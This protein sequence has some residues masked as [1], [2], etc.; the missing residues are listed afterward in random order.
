MSGLEIFLLIIL[1]IIVIGAFFYFMRRRAKSKILSERYGHKPSHI[2]LYFEEYFDDIIH[3]WDLVEKKEAKD[4]ANNMDK[5]LGE[6]S[7]EI[8]ELQSNKNRISSEFD[9]I[10]DRVHRIERKSKEVE[11]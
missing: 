7:K 11:K 8:D 6:I 1:I 3:N 9:Q 2:E 4:W 10:E 5:R